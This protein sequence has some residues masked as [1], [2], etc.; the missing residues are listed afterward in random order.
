[1]RFGPGFRGY[2]GD[3]VVGHFG[4]ASQDVLEVSAGI[5]GPAPAAFDEGV[6]DRA[7]FSGIGLA[8]EKPVL[9]VMMSCA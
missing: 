6:N 8:H 1:M 5:N 4:Q 2:F 3:L 9:L 7:A